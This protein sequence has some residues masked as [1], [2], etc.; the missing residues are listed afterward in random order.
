[1]N[2][3]RLS[4]V[5]GIL[6]VVNVAAEPISV[7]AKEY[8]LDELYRIALERAERI[9]L[10]AEDLNIA[11]TGKDRALSALLPKLSAF[12][13]YTKYSAEKYNDTGTLLQPDAATSWG[14]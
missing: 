5:V 2:D 11:K 6:L 3:W 4:L 8:S 10:S 9:K 7:H 12:G 13:N 1:M 14:V